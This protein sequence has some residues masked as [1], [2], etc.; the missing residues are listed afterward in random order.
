MKHFMIWENKAARFILCT[1]FWLA[2]WQ[3]VSFCAPAMLFASPVVTARALFDV[4]RQSAAWLAIAGTLGKTI[5]GFLLGFGIAMIFA[6][7]CYRSKGIKCL[8]M[9][10]VQMMKSVPVACFVVAALIWMP[11]RWLPVLVSFFVV[12]P[13]MY[14]HAESGLTSMDVNITEMAR[15]FHITQY[16][17]LRLIY[18]PQILPNILAGCRLSVGMCWKASIAGEIIGLPIHSIGEQLYLAKLYLEMDK[19]FAWTI[20]IIGIS[21]LTEKLVARGLHKL[22]RILELKDEY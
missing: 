19:L 6:V 4:L 7:L 11:S 8:L 16:K 12:F 9:P 2:V 20:L 15:V 21:L 18:L 3:T 14:I 13:V 1:V 10:A 22:Q 17:R 5:L